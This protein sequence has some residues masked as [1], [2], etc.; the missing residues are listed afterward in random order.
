MT[1]T[2]LQFNFNR[3]TNR[4]KENF[5]FLLHFNVN[6]FHWDLNFRGDA[7]LMKYMTNGEKH[8]LQID[9]DVFYT[10]SADLCD[11]KN[12]EDDAYDMYVFAIDEALRFINIMLY[13]DL[14]LKYN[15]GES[16]NDPS[17]DYDIAYSGKN[18][19]G[20]NLL[21]KKIKNFEQIFAE[22][23]YML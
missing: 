4:G 10:I 7:P 22:D 16:D 8:I 17:D 15:N 6:N 12:E 13:E 1:N 5:G 23:I 14:E 3:L 21:S 11:P 9:G 19:K 18:K 20:F 2:T